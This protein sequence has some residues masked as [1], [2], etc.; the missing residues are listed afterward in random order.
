[1]SAAFGTIAGRVLGPGGA[2]VAGATVAIAGG[3]QPHRDIAAVT[4]ADGSFRFGQVLPGRY[5]VEARQ[6]GVTRGAEVVVAAGAPA[7]VEIRFD[8]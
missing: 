8:E 4:A 1:M 5:R 6:K 7:Q 2:P 3:E